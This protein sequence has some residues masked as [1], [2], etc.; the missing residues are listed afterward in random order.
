MDYGPRVTTLL[1]KASFLQ[2]PFDRK[3]FGKN[4]YLGPLHT[5]A[6]SRDQEIVRA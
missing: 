4:L 6:K 5:R 2:V 1:A 3:I